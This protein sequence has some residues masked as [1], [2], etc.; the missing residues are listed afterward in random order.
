[1]LFDD[2]NEAQCMAGFFIER[3]LGKPAFDVEEWLDGSLSVMNL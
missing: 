2:V 1:M 3:P